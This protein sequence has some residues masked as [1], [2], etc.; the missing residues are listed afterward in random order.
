MSIIKIIPL[1]SYYDTCVIHEKKE[2]E[3]IKKIGEGATSVVF[4]LKCGNI[5]KIY[6]GK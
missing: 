3:I 5:M 1:L 4:L 2:I 6:K